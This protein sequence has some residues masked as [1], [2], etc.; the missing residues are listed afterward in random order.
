MKVCKVLGLHRSA[1]FYKP[2]ESRLLR[3]KVIVNRLIE[4]SGSRPRYGYLRLHVLV[5]REG[6]Q[7]TR[8]T[9]HRYYTEE[10]LQLRRKTK[11]KRAKHVRH[12]PPVAT[13]SNQVWTL[14]FM[15]DRLSCGKKIRI[16]NV[17]DV[18]SRKCVGSFV[19]HGVDAHKV[20]SFLEVITKRYSCPKAV[21]VDNGSEFTSKLFDE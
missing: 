10:G 17:L 4:L 9:V 16:L 15:H 1:F 19:D 14:D 7:V 12:T 13:A 3:K 21:R 5:K 11:K 2:K 18:F 8:N 6:F 20:V